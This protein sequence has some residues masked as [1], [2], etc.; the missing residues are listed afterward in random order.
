MNFETKAI[1]L[2][3]HA[4]RGQTRNDGVTPYL[5]HVHD[6]V[7]RVGRI[8]PHIQQTPTY[9]AAAWLHDVVEDTGVTLQELTDL[10]FSSLTVQIVDA[11]T[12]REGETY[13]DFIVRIKRHSQLASHIKI[14]DI[15]SNLNDSPRDGQR[16][17][18]VHALEMLLSSP[19]G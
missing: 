12:R 6:V 3:A 13:H 18:Y 1:E 7:Q 10:G 4:H 5:E 14:A 8:Y 9:V 19:M 16:K 2:A 15:L 11:L 17:R